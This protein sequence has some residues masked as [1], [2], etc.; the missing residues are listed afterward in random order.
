MNL[1]SK[2]LQRQAEG[3]PVRVGLIGAGKFGS[4]YLAQIPRTP[5]VHLVGIADLSPSAAQANLARVGWEA[6]RT[7]AGSLA[8]AVKTGAT[9]SPTTGRRFVKP[10]GHRRDRRVHRNPVAAVEHCPAA[11]K[12][13]KEARRQRHRR[14]RCLLRGAAGLAPPGPASSTRWRFGDQPALICDLVDWART[15]GFR[16]WARAAATSGCRTLRIH[17]RDGVGPLRPDA[18]AGEARRAEPEDVQQLPRRLQPL[19]RI[20]RGVQRHRFGGAQ[21]RP[22]VPTGQRGRH[23]LR[24]AAE[25][26]RRRAREEG[27]GRGDLSLEPDGRKIPYDI[28]MACGSRSRPRPSTSRT[29]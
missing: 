6:Q 18:R 23:S 5:G 8:E 12:E 22:A 2:L 28:R 11:F 3:R 24:D 15:C 4:M 26:R 16:W 20:D 21:Q 14:G 10:S 19:H 7:Q 1:H 29:A 25:E 9:M 27:H 13:K 17:A